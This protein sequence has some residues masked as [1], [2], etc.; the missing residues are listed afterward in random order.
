MNQPT[1]EVQG[2]RRIIAA[3]SVGTLIEWYD[4]YIFGSLAT[5][6][7]TQ[8]FPKTN[9]TAA[10]LSTFATFAAGF[11]VRP[12][13]ALVFGRLGD[14]IGRKYTFLL[15][16]IIMGS[17]TFAIGLVPG[18]ETIGFAAPILV[19]VLRLL[20]GLA[21]GGEYG[22]AATYVAEHAPPKRRGFFTSWIQTTA[23]LG[24]FLSLGI[25]LIT[26]HSLDIDRAKSIA[27]FN[28]WGWRIP[29]LVSIFLV[30][31]SVYIR[32]KMK[33]SPM[34]AKLKI[35][36]KTSSNP[37]KESFTHRSNLKMVLLA[38]FGATMGQGVVWYTG[39]FYAQSFIENICKVDFEQSRTILIWAILFA[40][41]FF[42]F[43]GGW[44]DRVGR[45]WIMMIGMLLAIITYRPLFGQLLSIADVNNKIELP[46]QKQINTTINPFAHTGN[47]LRIVSTKHFFSDGMVMTETKTDT[48]YADLSKT[49]IKPD[50]KLSKL[51]SKNDYWM[52]VAIVF[53]MIIYVTMVYGP[54]AA[55]LVEMFPTKIR[56]TSMSLPYHIG[57]G[58]FGGLTPFIALLLTTIY[59]TDKLVGLFYPMIVAGVC[60]LIGVLYLRNKIDSDVND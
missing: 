56:Y 14:L 51:I 35:E 11:I 53:L 3:S 41:P 48:A 58:I 4:F 18:Y 29:F 33:E 24:L 52:M 45:K 39:Q 8:F 27:K 15:T 49:T 21:L 32:L 7:A 12:F 43:F 17:S 9:P 30:V 23:T 34:Y 13:G 20:Q 25:I 54:I 60:L 1:N 44:S 26:R 10:L 59:S 42:V 31:I 2:I 57:N 46:E 47:S 38:L 5:V 37:L 36:G 6:I 19:L 50:I 28:D 16:L 40:T 55:F 22:G